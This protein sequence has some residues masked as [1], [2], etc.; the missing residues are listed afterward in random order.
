VQ[1]GQTCGYGRGSVDG[2]HLTAIAVI[3]DAI[4][5]SNVYDT[6]VIQKDAELAQSS[7]RPRSGDRVKLRDCSMIARGTIV[8][9]LTEEFVRVQWDDVPT[10]AMHRR[11]ALERDAEQL[12]SDAPSRPV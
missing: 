3:T 2:S 6:I 7:L 9:E 8:D 11:E 4:P 10:P 12:D 5:E 1:Y